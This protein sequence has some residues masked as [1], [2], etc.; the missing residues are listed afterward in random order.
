MSIFRR[1]DEP[2]AA[3]AGTEAAPTTVPAARD[4][5]LGVPP[6]RPSGVAL[7]SQAS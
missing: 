3:A 7:P 5:D 6:F 1:K 4:P 2:G